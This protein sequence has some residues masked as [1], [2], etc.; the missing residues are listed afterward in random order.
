MRAF[1]GL[2]V[3]EPLIAPLLSVQEAIPV[4]RKVPEENLH[5]TLA[6]LGDVD[7]PALEALHEA[8]EGRRL[9]RPCL[10]P[11]GIASYGGAAPRLLAMDFRADPA[12]SELHGVAVRAARGAGIALRRER[13]RPH[14][15]L[16]R[17]AGGGLSRGGRAALGRALAALEVPAMPEAQAERLALYES[18]LAPEGAR[19]E[20]LAEY[21]LG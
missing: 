14:V 21:P 18:I 17:F 19:Y 3:P 5:L 16:I 13:F 6:F 10:A 20:V 9:A 1:L 2:P 7:E 12:L 11:A 4:G 8:L 15:T